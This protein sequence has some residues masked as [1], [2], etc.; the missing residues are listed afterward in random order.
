MQ[1]VQCLATAGVPVIYGNELTDSEDAAAPLS[2]EA[3]T[4][5]NSGKMRSGGV[6]GPKDDPL[7]PVA[8]E[9]VDST[10]PW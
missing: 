3:V 6:L 8:S 1:L 5:G 7:P 4:E 10:A 9:S 2:L